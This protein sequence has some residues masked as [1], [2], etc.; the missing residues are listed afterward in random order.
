MPPSTLFWKS[1]PHRWIRIMLTIHFSSV[2]RKIVKKIY[3]YSYVIRIKYIMI[4]NI[5][6]NCDK[7]SQWSNFLCDFKWHM[8]THH[9]L[10]EFS[11]PWLVSHISQL[12]KSTIQFP[13]YNQVIVK[14]VFSILLPKLFNYLYHLQYG[15]KSSTNHYLMWTSYTDPTYC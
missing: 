2:L 5:Q 15:Y 7:I 14:N 13:I 8:K 4:M 6:S 11:F 1:L 10:H 9:Y 3:Y 12:L